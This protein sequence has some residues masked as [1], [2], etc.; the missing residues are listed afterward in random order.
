M[1]D[2]YDS[3]IRIPEEVGMSSKNLSYIDDVM[4]RAIREKVMKGMVTLVARHGKIVQF[5]AYGKADEEKPM[6]RDA[7][8]RLASM[9]KTIG[10]VALMQ[11]FDQG[12]VMMSDPITDYL[13]GFR[14][15][16]VFDPD[17]PGRL[18]SANREI[19]IHD[20]LTMT[21]GI[22]SIQSAET[23]HPGCVYCA[24]AYR[25]AGIIDTMHPL[26]MTLGQVVDQLADMPLASQPGSRWE[27][28]NLTS[29][30]A[31]RIVELVSGLDL[32]TYL[33]KYIFEP[34]AMKETTFY[35]DQAVWSRIPAVFACDTMERL[36]DLDV[37]GT[38]TTRLAFADCR[39]YYNIA[40]GLHGTVYDYFRF[41]QML[42]NKGELEGRRILSPNAIHLMT[43]NHIGSQR[44]RLYGHGWG[45]MMNVQVDYNTVFNYMGTGSYGWHGYWGSVYNVWPDKD[46]VA[47]MI[48]QVSPVGPSW[49][50]QERFL[51]V[52]ANSVIISTIFQL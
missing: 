8:F 34:L 23:G 10:G 43:R 13:P 11:L 28:S 27:Y 16:K 12:R 47:I 5:K 18:T 41:A 33:K 52:V 42:C 37:P 48:S 14:D 2:K 29:L 20:L 50:P 7:I 46:L 22:V 44:T 38:D 36:D 4:E 24:N 51:N 15:M 9:S 40:A 26:D 39:K 32:N 25:E 17:A 31:G 6:T 49:K 35:P 3:L 1:T 30:V 21:A 45:Y 19:T